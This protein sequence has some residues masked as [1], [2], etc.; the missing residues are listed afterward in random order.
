MEKYIYETDIFNIGDVTEKEINMEPGISYT[1]FNCGVEF[2][3]AYDKSCFKE[4]DFLANTEEILR[5]FA[6]NYGPGKYRIQEINENHA[7]IIR[8]NTYVKKEIESLGGDAVLQFVET[9]VL[10]S[11]Y[12]KF[13][14]SDS[15]KM[16]LAHSLESI[17]DYSDHNY[18]KLRIIEAATGKDDNGNEVGIFVGFVDINDKRLVTTA[19]RFN[20][21][22]FPHITTYSI[23]NAQ[24]G[25]LLP[26]I[27]LI[28]SEDDKTFYSVTMILNMIRFNVIEDDEKVYA[29]AIYSFDNE[30]AFSSF[31]DSEKKWVS[32]PYDI[33]K[34]DNINVADKGGRFNKLGVSCELTHDTSYS[35]GFCSSSINSQSILS[36]APNVLESILSV[37]FKLNHVFMSNKDS[38][39][40]YLITPI[41]ATEILFH[42]DDANVEMLSPNKFIISAELY[43][44][45][46][47][48][49]T[50]TLGSLDPSVGESIMKVPGKAPGTATYI[51]KGET[52]DL[53]FDIDDHTSIT[54]TD[55]GKYGAE[56]PE[57]ECLC[58]NFSDAFFMKNEELEKLEEAIRKEYHDDEKTSV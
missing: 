29:I 30:I 33:W 58:W 53:S 10:S 46:T 48:A 49:S 31:M 22:E 20:K 13:D 25:V 16:E 52:R 11:Y 27:K 8:D 12:T 45:F 37:N 6:L 4:K 7:K 32:I 14:I 56:C 9:E 15:L 1:I 3:E 21:K 17:V 50:L 47:S 40:K 34:F 2:N 39:F 28:S 57:G 5:M 54:I 36:F 18:H 19:F 38:G 42:I 55:Y 44:I 26:V 35:L 24:N 23:L 43:G 51:G 41:C